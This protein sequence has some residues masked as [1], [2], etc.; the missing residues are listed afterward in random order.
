[1][2]EEERVRSQERSVVNR[3]VGGGRRVGLVLTRH[4]LCLLPDQEA[5]LV[6]SG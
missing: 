4:G 3:E 1:M 6:G 2:R 5:A